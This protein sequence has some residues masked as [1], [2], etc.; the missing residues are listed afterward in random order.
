MA[1][2]GPGPWGAL[3]VQS[4]CLLTV[5]INKGIRSGPLNHVNDI[6]LGRQR[7]EGSP[8]AFHMHSSSLTT[9]SKFALQ[10]F[11]IPMLGQMLQ[12]KASSSFFKLVL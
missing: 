8:L 4:F 10:T 11:G 7:G 1:W 6:Y 3:E 5:H 2:T 12:R 9:S